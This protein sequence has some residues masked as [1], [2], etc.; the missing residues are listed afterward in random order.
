LFDIVKIHLLGRAQANKI[1]VSMVEA[2]SLKREPEP[3]TLSLPELGKKIKSDHEALANSLR[4]I[5]P[6]A[7]GIG[8]DLNAAK[9]LVGHGGFLKWVKLNCS[10]TDKTA[11][12]YMKLATDKDKLSAKLRELKQPGDDEFEMLSNL[13]LAKAERLISENSGSGGTGGGDN[14]SDAY[15]RAQ[16]KLLKTLEAFSVASAEAAVTETIA[17]LN[18][19][20]EAKKRTL[21][22]A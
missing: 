9:A 12:R 16:D 2:T 1:G 7:W 13:S 17:R 19:V 5:V 4:G 11:E 15:D 14:A 20:V 3:A 18:F 22:V 21:K 10:M 6:R 8:E